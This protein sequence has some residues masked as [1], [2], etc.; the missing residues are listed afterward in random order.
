MKTLETLDEASQPYRYEHQ[1]YPVTLKTN[2]SASLLS[3][4]PSY[5]FLA[6]YSRHNYDFT[7]KPCDLHVFAHSFGFI[8]NQ[9]FFDF[10]YVESRRAFSLYSRP[11]FLLPHG[12]L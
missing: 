3:Q 5:H 1:T 9:Q 2:S 10:R 11:T 8:T 4:Q 7:W 6:V 12:M